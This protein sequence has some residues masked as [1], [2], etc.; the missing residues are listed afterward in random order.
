VLN[1]KDAEF[2][3]QLGKREVRKGCRSFFLHP[4]TIFIC[5]ICYKYCRCSVY[6]EIFIYPTN[7]VFVGYV[8]IV[9]SIRPSICLSFQMS[10]E[11]NSSL[12]DEPILMKFCKVYTT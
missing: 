8:G 5:Y 12:T 9:L 11:L 1:P 3:P 2:K 10:F 4:G 6:L 7:E